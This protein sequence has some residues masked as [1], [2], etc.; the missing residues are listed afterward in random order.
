MR[1]LAESRDLRKEGIGW[2]SMIVIMLAFPLLFF[3]CV[4]LPIWLGWTVR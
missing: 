1:D 4:F 2:I 3:L